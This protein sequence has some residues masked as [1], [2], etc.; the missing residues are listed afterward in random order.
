MDPDMVEST[1]VKYV[2][3]LNSLLPKVKGLIRLLERIENR[4]GI[5]IHTRGVTVTIEGNER[6]DQSR[7]P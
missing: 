6:S 2:A 5:Y 3:F 7:N 4:I 1:W